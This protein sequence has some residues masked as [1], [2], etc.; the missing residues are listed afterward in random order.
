LAWWKVEVFPDVTD[1]G[2]LYLHRGWSHF[3]C[4]LDLHDGYSLVLR[5]DH[6]SQIN[7]MVFDIT[8]CRKQYPH[9]F[10][11]SGNQLSLLI[12]EPMSFTVILK[13]YH[14]KA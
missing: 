2:H 1:G 7:V 9:N 6:R 12:V 11:A 3:A 14:L 13:K 5:C 4:T 8:N 10:E